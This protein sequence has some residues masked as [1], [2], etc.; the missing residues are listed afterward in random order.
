MRPD[1]TGPRTDP[2]QATGTVDE[3]AELIDEA[4]W[5]RARA[6]TAEAAVERA[7]TQL[8]E[9]RERLAATQG[10]LAAARSRRAVRIVDRL[11]RAARHPRAF[12]REWRRRRGAP[13][14]RTPSPAAPAA[15]ASDGVLAPWSGIAGPDADGRASRAR[16][17]LGARGVLSRRPRIAGVLPADTARALAYDAELLSAADADQQR[18]AEFDPDVLLVETPRHEPGDV[19]VTPALSPEA[20]APLLARCDERSIPTAI[21]L[22]V[23]PQHLDTYL[24][25]AAAFDHVFT[26]DVDQIPYLRR[27]LGHDRVWFLPFA[28]QPRLY[29]PVGDEERRPV[30]VFA[31]GHYARATSRT[32][33][34][35]VVVDALQ[36]LTSLEILDP[37]IHAVLPHRRYPE[38]YRAAVIGA[39]SPDAIPGAYRS[40]AFGVSVT[41]A[42]ASSSLVPRRVLELLMSGTPVLSTY[43]RGLRAVLGAV[44]PAADGVAPL[45]R[46]IEQLLRDS[47]ARERLAAAGLRAVLRDHTYRERLRTMFAVMS[48]EPSAPLTPQVVAISRPETP[49]DV[50]LL[51]R[52]LAAQQAVA[53]RGVVVTDD[54]AIGEAAE[55]EACTVIS[56]AEART[57]STQSV[58][59]GASVAMLDP[60]DWY[61]PHYL[62]SLAQA[63]QYTEAE[64]ATKDAHYLAAGRRATRSADGVAHRLRT[65]GTVAPR[66]SLLLRTSPT[67]TVADLMA[68]QIAPR[69]DSVAVDPFDYCAEG[70]DGIDIAPAESSSLTAQSLDEFS[71]RVL[72]GPLTDEERPPTRVLDPRHWPLTPPIG[73]QLRI[74]RHGSRSLRVRRER[75]AGVAYLWLDARLAVAELVSDGRVTVHLESRGTL[76]VRIIARWFDR[77]GVIL[78][79]D[80]GLSGFDHTF[81]PPPGA[82]TCQFAVRIAGDGVTDIRMLA[83]G[84]GS[85]V[86]PALA[87]A[88]APV[89]VLADAYPSYENLYRYAFVHSR[90][91]DYRRRGVVADVFRY[92]GPESPGW[93]EF[94]GFEVETGGAAALRASL[95]RPGRTH[96]LVHFLSA[97]LWEVLSEEADRLDITVW[98]HGSDLQ[99]WWRRVYANEGD[100]EKAKLSTARRH[101]FWKD[102]LADLPARLGFVFVSDHFMRESLSDIERDI[103][104]HQRAVIHNP[105]D[106]SIFEYREKP[107]D[108]RL[109]ILSIRPYAGPIYANDLSVAAVLDLAAE[110]WFDQL[111]FRFIGDGPYFEETLAPVRGFANVIVERRY[112]SQHQIADLH[113]EYGVFLVP[114]RADTHGVSRDE[115]MSSGLVPVTSAVAAVPEFVS[116]AEGYLAPRDD[117]KALADAIRDLYAHPEV[118]RRKSRAAA[119]RIRRQTAADVIVPRELEFGLWRTR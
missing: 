9:A 100:L 94:E 41:T 51:A 101:P 52:T 17:R 44:V 106:T 105:I 10:Q 87:E 97:E 71:H 111:E 12:L 28:A 81:E 77:A 6:D 23:D 57:L 50:R 104:E 67:L 79:S 30:A 85:A 19:A 102:L 46:M 24:D 35:G 29:H 47:E 14:A 55:G 119:E 69:G 26:P 68:E 75:D 25:L 33:D 89:L 74:D 39:R 5:Q 86:R 32:H 42:R 80:S 65:T 15:T 117:A 54:P 21:W 60:R 34:F 114:T 48:G 2:L 38:R 70:A 31:G 18:F 64:W 91:R 11:T 56:S 7:R 22:T 73:S 20:L 90:V 95:R 116:D 83:V 96:V 110:P 109:R 61:G 49:D 88:A 27:D 8:K 1:A 108:A 72:S 66:R 58:A 98:V 53:V 16:A 113:R 63:A 4:E 118:F 107:D 82:V 3:A 99:G 93:Y 40:A 59:E 45:R 103:P 43:A 37:H 36:G 84:S 112:L 13:P 115:A 92:H 78:R 76:D 62:Q